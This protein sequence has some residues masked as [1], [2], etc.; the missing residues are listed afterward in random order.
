[1][2]LEKS[3]PLEKSEIVDAENLLLLAI[4]TSNAEILDDLLH[5]DLQFIQPSGVT[6]T[7]ADDLEV[8]RTG[9]MKVTLLE[10]SDQL[11]NIIDNTAVV[12]VTVNM[13]GT[14]YD[15]SIKG[16]F[17]Y[18]RVWLLSDDHLSVI[19]GSCTTIND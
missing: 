18:I 12:S 7:K 17:R 13:E 6:I 2:S 14:F 10:A 8:Y 16:K 3:D 1:M 5:E 15:Q 4:Q 9:A 19:A 11:I